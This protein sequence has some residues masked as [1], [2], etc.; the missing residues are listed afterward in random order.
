MLFYTKIIL[1]IYINYVICSDFISN[2][3]T[4]IKCSLPLLTEYSF[5]IWN[6]ITRNIIIKPDPVY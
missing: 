6:V 5:E 1:H 3:S 2:F 4:L